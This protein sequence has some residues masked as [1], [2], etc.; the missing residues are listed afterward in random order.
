MAVAVVAATI[1]EPRV[2]KGASK[3]S[4]STGLRTP[5]TTPIGVTVRRNRVMR[6]SPPPVP[7]TVMVD[8]PVGVVDD[9]VMVSVLVKL[10]IPDVGLNEHDAPA[11]SPLVHIRLTLD[12]V[13]LVRVAMIELD[14]IKPT[15]VLIEPEL[16][17]SK[18]DPTVNHSHGLV[19]GK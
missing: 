14:P 18:S 4:L 13:P 16:F 8:Q 6:V 17:R 5:P 15:G 10:A 11:G 19:D 9:A 2:M 1:R 3:P 12:D 7:V